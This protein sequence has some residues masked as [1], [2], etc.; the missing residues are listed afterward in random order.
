MEERRTTLLLLYDTK[1][2]LNTVLKFL[3][4][5]LVDHKESPGLYGQQKQSYIT[6]SA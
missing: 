2:Q 5:I 3:E 6:V 4:P 1:N